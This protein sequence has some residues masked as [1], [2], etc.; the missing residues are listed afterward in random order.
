MK[1]LLGHERTPASVRQSV[2]PAVRRRKACGPIRSSLTGQ[3]R[4]TATHCT[5]VIVY[6]FTGYR[7]GT[8]IIINVSM[9]WAAVS[10]SL[11]TEFRYRINRPVSC[12]HAQRSGCSSRRLA[13]FRSYCATLGLRLPAHPRTSQRH[14]E[15]G[16]AQVLWAF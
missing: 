4:Q 2:S 1:K 10:A 9:G 11:Y 8:D 14:A 16:S 6:A 7:Y 13:K 15:M 5:Q 3:T 12:L